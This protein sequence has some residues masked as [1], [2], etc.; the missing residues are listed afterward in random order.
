[1]YMATVKFQRPSSFLSGLIL[2]IT[3]AHLAIGVFVHGFW[4]IAENDHLLRLYFDCEG[5]LLLLLFAALQAVLAVSA[6]REF[7]PAQPLRLAW[8]YI[9]LASIATFIGTVFRHLLAV[10]IAMNPLR[11]AMSDSGVRLHAMFAGIGTV[12]GGP[13]QM[14]L[15]GTGFYIVLRVYRQFGMLAKLKPV[16]KVLIGVAGLY[17]AVVIVGIALTI[18]NHPSTVT[19]EHALTWPGDYLVSVLLLEAV[20]LRRS[21]LDMGWGY[22]SKVWSA[23]IA[24]IFLISFCSLMNW[25]TAFGVFSWVHTAF[26]WYLWY[27]AS[28]A[29]ALA[30][31]YQW[32]AMRTAQA[33]LTKQLDELE[34]SPA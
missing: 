31:A 14:I 10:D 22:L 20:I 3:T 34:M 2:G 9:M 16:D 25:L 29:F 33:R 23:F 13:I 12:V 15:L 32:E 11:Y 5:T 18:R 24:G 21:S 1:M 30:P 26:V 19:S 8:M 7:S 4:L 6:Y 28:A 27:P 17:A